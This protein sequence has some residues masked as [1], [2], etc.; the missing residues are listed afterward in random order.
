M[1][2]KRKDKKGRILNNNEYQ[3]ADGR[4]EYRYSQNGK[5]RSVYSWRLVES[6]A[7]PK[8]K[9]TT[10]A[11]RT[12]EKK[13]QK[14]LLEGVNMFSAKKTTLNDMFKQLMIAKG[15]RYRPST[16]ANYTY[17][18]NYYARDTIGK[19]AL[20]DLTP[21]YIVSYYN[22]LK[23]SDLS[24]STL[25]NIHCLLKMTCDLAV[26]GKLIRE[27]PF[28]EAKKIYFGKTSWDSTPKKEALTKPQEQLL[29]KLL[30]YERNCPAYLQPMVTVALN[31]GLRAGELCALQFDDLD[32]SQGIIFVRNNLTAA[33]IEGKREY[34]IDQ[35]KTERGIRKVPMLSIVKETLLYLQEQEEFEPLPQIGLA[36]FD[37]FVFTK[38]R[39]PVLPESF[40]SNLYRLINR[41]NAGVEEQAKESGEEP[42]LLPYISPHILR[43]TFATRLSEYGVPIITISSLLGHSSTRVTERIYISK[44]VDETVNMMRNLDDLI[45][46]KALGEGSVN[47]LAPEQ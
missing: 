9:K 23:T 46:H 26:S 24:E 13:I 43:H 11:L 27:N 25:F 34:F 28:V 5:A 31:T 17:I 40:R 12:L 7:T 47:V 19:M 37:N 21:L 38:K 2:V 15:D 35:P 6:D 36:G 3:K 14:D 20:D 1:S 45:G 44:Q 42:E 39:K 16:K 4:Y 10:D 29:L 22:G 18:Y 33:T 8:G 41:Y 30:K 32:F